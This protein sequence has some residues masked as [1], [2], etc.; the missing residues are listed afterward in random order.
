MNMEGYTTYRE[1]VYMVK[2]LLKDSSDDTYFTEEHIMFLFNKYR[3]M[4]IRRYYKEESRIPE[5]LKQTL[6]LDLERNNNCIIGKE[7]LKSTSKIPELIR[8][9]NSNTGG[10][11]LGLGDYYMNYR[12]TFVSFERFPYTNSNSFLKN[13]VYVAI[14]PDRKLNINI[15]G[16]LDASYLKQIQLTGVFENPSDAGKYSCEKSEVNCDDLD[17]NIYLDNTLQAIIIKAIVQDLS[18][19]LYKPKDNVNNAKDDLSNNSVDNYIRNSRGA[20]M[21]NNEEE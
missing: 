19:G 15:E 11:T 5:N 12:L 18:F 16:N 10:I 20:E 3:S 17:R 9:N 13:I 14:S 6:C 7:T 1:I 4:F 21:S 2:D 8:F